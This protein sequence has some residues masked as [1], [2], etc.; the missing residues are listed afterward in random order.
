MTTEEMKSRKRELGYTNKTISER[1]GIPLSTVQKIFSGATI[2]P[3][4]GT[5]K[6]LERLLRPPFALSYENEARTIFSASQ[7][8]E[9]VFDYI[10]RGE[11]FGEDETGPY[12]M[13]D[14]YALPDE[15]RVELID[16]FFYDMA[17]P[18][19][20]HQSI[21]GYIYSVL[22]SFAGK[23][24]GT[25]RPLISPLDVQLDKDNKTMLQPDVLVVCDSSKIKTDRI[26]GAPDLVIEV[27][28][29]STRRKDM[30]VKMSKYSNAG[31]REYWMID[32]DKKAVVQYNLEN[33]DLPV[34]Y[35]FDMKI[36]VLIWEGACKVDLKEMNEELDFLGEE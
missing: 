5:V 21:A 18:N 8:R 1:T 35:S 20:I 13:D 11:R 12:R 26:Y 6:A 27:L 36:P 15:Q 4:E 17:A 34:I 24:K 25:C 23:H 3:R 28:S 2:S 33:L 19:V 9:R 22:L 16:G 14:Y 30:L 10:T 32:P 31:V 7:V 29:P